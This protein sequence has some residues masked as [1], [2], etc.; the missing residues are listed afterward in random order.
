MLVDRLGYELKSKDISLI[1]IPNFEELDCV[2]REFSHNSINS[3]QLVEDSRDAICK[4]IL[5]GTNNNN[6]P[7]KHFLRQVGHAQFFKKNFYQRLLYATL[8]HMQVNQYKGKLKLPQELEE[9]INLDHIKLVRWGLSQ[10]SSKYGINHP[11]LFQE[12][13]ISINLD[14]LKKT[15]KRYFESLTQHV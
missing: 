9:V 4:Y 8:A 3:W 11:R 15:Q 13:P 14:L 10:E 5:E 2:Q 6:Q 12:L 7:N 1:F